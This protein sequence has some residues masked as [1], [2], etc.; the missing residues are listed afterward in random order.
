[1]FCLKGFSPN[2]TN[3]SEANDSKKDSNDPL[4]NNDLQDK[5]DR[6]GFIQ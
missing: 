6:Y 5:I 4:I 2:E 3:E 1:M